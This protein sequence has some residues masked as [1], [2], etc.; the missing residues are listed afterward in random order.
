MKICL[1][2]PVN[3]FQVYQG[4]LPPLAPPSSLTAKAVAPNAP[5]TVYVRLEIDH[6]YNSLGQDSQVTMAGTRTRQQISLKDTSYY[7]EIL[8]IAPEVSKG[9]QDIVITGR[10][11]D[12]ATQ[13]PLADAA[14]NLFITVNGF[15]RKIPVMTGSDGTFTHTFEPLEEEAASFMSMRSTRIFW[16]GRTRAALS[17]TRSRSPRPRSRCLSP[18]TMSRRSALR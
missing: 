18:G 6:I 9:D 5:D 12:R 8:S 17:S 2:T 15:E 1:I 11:I 10:A 14:L 13:E 3:Q 16:T 7:G 4:G